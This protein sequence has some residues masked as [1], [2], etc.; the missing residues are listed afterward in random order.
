MGG[1][2]TGP[3]LRRPI[4]AL[5]LGICD[6]DE[7]DVTMRVR[8]IFWAVS[9][10]A[11]VALLGGLGAGLGAQ[12]Q[13]H[14]V[15][16][17]DIERG[18]QTFLST[19]AVCHGADGDTIAGVNLASGTFRHATTDQELVDIIRNGIPGTAMPPN[20]LQEA[21]AALVVAYLRS[22]PATIMASKT[23]GLRG[24]A[25]NGKTIFDKSGCSSCHLVKGS[26]GFLGPD[27][28]S[29]GLTRRSIELERA[30]TDP[31][32]DL[33]TGNRTA[34]VLAKDG[35]TI[36]G[37]LLNQ[38]T[39]SLQ[40]I[41]AKGKLLSIQKDTVRH[42]EVMATSAMPSFTNRLTAQDLA[43]VVSY[44]QTLKTPVPAGG[45]N[46]GGGGFGGPGGP[47]G[48][49]GGGGGRAGRGGRQ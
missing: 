28:S 5:P 48:A 31:G 2:N 34:K 46:R 13:E 29:V 26:G 11:L 22:L 3:L 35:T 16:P 8:G 45:G 18:G 39:Y 37:R 43:D 25:A 40:L 21:Q 14:G 20:N 41:D 4:R 49:P 24:D 44:L 42:W 10:M 30:L 27:L 9:A 36:I 6:P 7:G 17:A 33:R 1:P 12:D 15:T 38:D 19:C 32:A 23:S 47:G